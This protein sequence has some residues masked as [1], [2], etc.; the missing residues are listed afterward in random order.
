MLKCKRCDATVNICCFECEGVCGVFES[1]R[2]YGM[3]IGSD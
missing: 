2:G 1:W 3:T